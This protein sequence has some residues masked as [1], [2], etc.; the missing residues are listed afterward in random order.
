M[1]DAG[2]VEQLPWRLVRLVAGQERFCTDMAVRDGGS[3]CDSAKQWHLR[4][5]SV[6]DTSL[7]LFIDFQRHRAELYLWKRISKRLR[8]R[9]AIAGGG[10]KD[11]ESQHSKGRLTAHERIDLLFDPGTF[12]EIDTLVLP[13][14]DKYTWTATARATATAS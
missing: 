4:R 9:R 11:V 6:V 2:L 7:R 13:R 10:A 5:C 8:D 3:Q 1:I 12:D 14:Y